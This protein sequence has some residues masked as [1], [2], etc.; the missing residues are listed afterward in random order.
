M[1][2]VGCSICAEVEGP[3]LSAPTL[4]H[5]MNTGSDSVRETH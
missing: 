4:L 5:Q 1:A 2:P 3:Q